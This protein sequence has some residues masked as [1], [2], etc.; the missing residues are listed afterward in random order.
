MKKLKCE[1]CGQTLLLIEYGKLA[2]KCPRCGHK[3]TIEIRQVNEQSPR[4]RQD[5][6]TS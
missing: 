2:I 5:N 1:V 4:D 6:R 3:E